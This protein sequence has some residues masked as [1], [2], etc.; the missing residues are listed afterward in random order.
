MVH[1]TVKDQINL[2]IQKRPITNVYSCQ[3]GFQNK[4]PIFDACEKPNFEDYP[5]ITYLQIAHGSK[6]LRKLCEKL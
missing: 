3:K 4:K 2:E 5:I 1:S 6:L